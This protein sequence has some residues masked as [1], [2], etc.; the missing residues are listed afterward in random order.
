[1][2]VRFCGARS[3]HFW[4]LTAAAHRIWLWNL[5]MFAMY[6]FSVYSIRI[7]TCWG[8][9]IC[10]N[11]SLFF[12][13][14]LIRFRKLRNSE[15]LKLEQPMEKKFTSM[16]RTNHGALQRTRQKYGLCREKSQHNGLRI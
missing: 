3:G 12:S 16:R 11:V 9:D 14:V 13:R 4:A 10:R 8:Q 2:V 7:D 5:S 6:H 15:T 1:M